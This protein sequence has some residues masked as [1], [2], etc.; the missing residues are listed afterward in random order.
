MSASRPPNTPLTQTSTRSPGSTRFGT[1]ASCPAEPVP[2]IAI[3]M[4]FFVRNT[5]RSIDCSSSMIRR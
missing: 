1:V 2:L 5:S 3:V 4:R